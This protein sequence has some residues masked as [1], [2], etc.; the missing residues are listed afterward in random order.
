M[1]AQPVR[2]TWHTA[3]FQGA[4]SVNADAVAAG[5]LVV[6][7]ADG[8]GDNRGAARAALVAAGA[9][10]AAPVARGPVN[11]L[12]SAQRAVRADP[13]ATDCV[14][15]VAQPTPTGYLIAWVGDVRAYAWLGADLR[16][17]TTDHTVAQYFRA[18]GGPVSTRMEHTVLT[19]MRTA[20]PSHFGRTALP[21]PA[22]LL[23][24]TDGVHR[25]L[26]HT[27]MTEVV[28][29]ATDPAAALVS[30][31]RAAGATD[32]ATAVTVSHAHLPP[33]IPQPTLP[34]AA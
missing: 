4:R 7:L 31:A 21:T 11:A 25:T 33:T 28:R 29:D 19:S 22:G 24:T 30:A 2:S 20:E 34:V 6:A 12:A 32:N 13:D 3:S 17:L 14:I 10:V 18:R 15:V 8:V 23:L 27:T 16:Q 1:N 5:R 26:T 9:A